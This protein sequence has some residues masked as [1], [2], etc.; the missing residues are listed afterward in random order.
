MNA[1]DFVQ[2]FAC[3]NALIAATY[4]LQRGLR[5]ASER[6]GIRIGFRSW[7]VSSQMLVA[8][9]VALPP[10]LRCLPRDRGPEIPWSEFRPPSEG[11]E[12]G[13]ALGKTAWKPKKPLLAAKPPVEDAALSPFERLVRWMD[14]GQAD[15][16]SRLLV[17]IWALGAGFFLFR[18]A[19][20]YR[21]LARLLS[22]AHPLRRVGKTAIVVSEAVGVPFSAR[23]KG[24]RWVAI[25]ARMVL[26]PGDFRLAIRHELQ[27]HRRGDTA[28]AMAIDF[29]LCFFFP[30]PMLRL[31]KKEIDELQEFS[32]DEALLGRKGISSHDYGSCLLRVAETALRF[33]ETHIGTL[34]M[35]ATPRNPVYFK[36]FLGR[37]IEMFRVAKD[38]RPR[39]W[40]GAT[41][42]VLAVSTAVTL[43]FGAERAIRAGKDRNVN[44]GSVVVDRSIQAIAEKALKEALKSER[45]R[46][47]FAIVADPRS[48]KILAVANQDPKRSGY[49]ALSEMLEPASFM[50]SIVAAQAIDEGLTTPEEK[51][52]CENGT[53]VYRG[54]TFHDWNAKG[55]DKLST[56]DTVGLSSDIC[57][58]KIGEKV[59]DEGLEKMLVRF[60]F[61]PEG[62]AKEFPQAKSGVLPLSRGRP[63]GVVPAVSAGYSFI[64]T[65][66]ELVQAYG[67]IANG[68]ELLKP[69]S[70]DA[71][72]RPDVLRRVVS[73]ESAEKMKEILR[74]VVLKGT[75]KGK[76]SSDRYSTAGKTATSYIPDLTK[77]DLMEGKKK[78]NFA[79]FIGFAPV[80]DPRVE[81][82]VGILDPN[83][84]TGAHGSTHAAPVFRR[85]AED[86]LD[87]LKVPSDKL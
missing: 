43:A 13:A 51:H 42:G 33:R 38:F 9:S 53:Y 2:V 50:K 69:K 85:I 6:A 61:G 80:K 1:R 22:S 56:E 7:I 70:A 3:M 71:D 87:H 49:W 14:S 25:P 62:S 17:A 5:A 48:G 72:D 10:L 18:F 45:A 68:G 73:A 21:K 12:T 15:G 65:P 59:G 34:C 63:A 41:V 35:A 67:A 60:G 64:T 86:V 46:A 19:R 52:S 82:Y 76:A 55:W 40:V 81:V 28:W 44:P 84:G 37:R 75:G 74:Q 57:A 66:L 26:V 29:M 32:C 54:K 16:F 83:D 47:G 23:L 77:W 31:W 8:V 58:M 4:L 39:R 30:N 11:M 24:I 36:S 78:G 20:E 79:G 27:H